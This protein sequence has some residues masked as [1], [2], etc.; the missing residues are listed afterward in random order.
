MPPPEVSSEAN[1]EWA[2]KTVRVV[3]PLA[4]TLWQNQPGKVAKLVS[5][6]KAAVTMLGMGTVKAEFHLRWLYALTGSEKP[7]L[8]AVGLR[9]VLAREK[10]AAWTACGGQLQC[11][12]VAQSL[13]A[14]EMAAAWQLLMV[15]ARQCGDSL[16]CLYIEP[17][18]G[19]VVWQISHDKSDKG[20]LEVKQQWEIAL[21]SF[22]ET[23]RHWFA[24]QCTRQGTGLF[25]A[26]TGRQRLGK[27]STTTA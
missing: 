13:E 6:S 1:A 27:W 26:S 15:R 8:K 9:V 25:C 22:G 18:E 16:K 14:P 5:A 7:P 19:E 21:S 11:V 23:C 24:V 17:A 10:E 20:V 4:N 3:D 12:G 2:G